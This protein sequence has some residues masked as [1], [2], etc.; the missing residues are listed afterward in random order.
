MD[1]RVLR[2][3]LAVAQTENISH[4]AELLHLTQPTLSRQLRELEQELGK[5][6]FHRGGRRI[7]LTEE[8]LLLRQRAAEIVELVDKAA[9]EVRDAGE[10]VA[11]DVYLGG[12]ETE[13]MALI[14]R[15]AKALRA[16]HPQ[17]RFHLY[18]GNA[19]DV[20]AR[21]D[22]GLLDFALI[23]QPFD[24]SKYDGIPLPHADR[25]G[26]LLRRDHP[27][28]AKASVTPKDLQTQPLILSNQSMTIHGLAGWLGRDLNALPVAA[29]YNLIYNASL[30]VAE[31]V[32]CALALDKLVSTGPDS[33][34]CFRPLDPPL[35]AGLELVWKRGAAF[36]KPAAKFL[37]L[38]KE[39]I[40][41]S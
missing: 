8:G 12:G 40:T 18:S 3:F 41:K 26:V 1:I 22:K 36:S 5:D 21:L 30:M 7:T 24:S 19:D 27:L 20:M 17:V 34:L 37:E 9:A 4:A 39:T 2:Y 31:G 38:L 15:T 33:P 32:G 35:E 16:A 14:A 25:W 28:A 6:L 29:T 13:A 23:I 11:G 10:T